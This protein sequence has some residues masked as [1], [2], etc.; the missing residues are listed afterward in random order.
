M[1]NSQT[2]ENWLLDENKKIL[3]KIKKKDIRHMP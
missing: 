1:R 3:K 2:E